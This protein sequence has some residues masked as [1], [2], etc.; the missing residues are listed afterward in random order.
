MPI[1]SYGAETRQEMDVYSAEFV[2]TL[3]TFIFKYRPLGRV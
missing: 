1:N 3:V 2:E